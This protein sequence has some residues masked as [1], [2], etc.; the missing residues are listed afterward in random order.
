[1][2]LPERDNLEDGDRPVVPQGR[3]A[4]RLGVP[5]DALQTS[6]F[7]GPCDRL[8]V[9]AI[10]VEPGQFAF[11]SGPVGGRS[12]VLASRCA[13]LTMETTHRLAWLWSQASRP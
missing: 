11:G 10:V 2:R 12:P 8:A 6:Q 9:A 1:M 5:G 3:F 13:V 7:L 4:T